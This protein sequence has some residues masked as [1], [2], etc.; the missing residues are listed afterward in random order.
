M[1]DEWL[2]RWER[3]QTGWHQANGSGALRKFWPQL[4]MGSRVLVP[5][6]GKSPDLLWLAG[7]GCDVTGVEL[8]EIAVRSF[9]AE[10]GIQF[11]VEEGQG[12]LWFRG[13]QQHLN[14]ACGDYFQFSDERFDALYDRAALVALPPAIRP[15]YVEHTKSLLKTD[16]TQLLI[17]LEY[18]QSKVNG[19]PFSVRPD[20]VKT[21]WP[22]L[23]R[24]DD[25]C[26]LTNMPSKFLD[27][28]LNKFGEA[29]WLSAHS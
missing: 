12:L 8:S 26:A 7:Q 29:V 2:A 13:V 18:D 6:C 19:P 27:A 1:N 5:L 25:L 17:T 16:A 10:T 23:Q 9:F 28:G 20:E 3:G 21:Y 24:V 22:E 4:T 15:S 11:E 14:I